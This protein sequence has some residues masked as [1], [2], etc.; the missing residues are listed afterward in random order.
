[1]SEIRDG[2]GFIDVRFVLGRDED[3]VAHPYI[4]RMERMGYLLPPGTTKDH[5]NYAADEFWDDS[6]SLIEDVAHIFRGIPVD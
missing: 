2:E 1:M 6:H 5:L 4:L 3:P